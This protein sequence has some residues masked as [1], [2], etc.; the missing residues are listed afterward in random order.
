MKKSITLITLL[1]LLAVSFVSCGKDEAVV[2]KPTLIGNWGCQ[3]DG[4]SVD[5]ILNSDKSYIWTLYFQNITDVVKGIYTYDEVKNT[6]TFSIKSSS[7]GTTGMPELS[8]VKLISSSKWQSQ[9]GS[10]LLIW[11]KK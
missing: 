3:A 1:L 10:Q 5:L 8:E 6:I 7:Y 2:E 9:N 4:Y 11:N